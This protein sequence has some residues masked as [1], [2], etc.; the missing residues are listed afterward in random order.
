[1]KS[2]LTIVVSLFLLSACGTTS[3]AVNIKV[4]SQ[5]LLNYRK[6][7]LPAKAAPDEAVI[8]FIRPY[9]SKSVLPTESDLK[10]D[11]ERQAKAKGKYYASTSKT[12]VDVYIDSKK[13]FALGTSE[14]Y[15]VKSKTGFLDVV[16]DRTWENHTSQRELI[17]VGSSIGKE[18]MNPDDARSKP[19]KLE[20]QAGKTY[21]VWINEGFST[22][23]MTTM[24]KDQFIRH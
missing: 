22:T 13:A 21:Y 5:D 8:Y 23:G 17:S 20:V 4:P 7:V 11:A 1:M 19:K 3:P 18:S 16:L 15:Y 24:A 12:K 9:S 14:N 6:F 10:R 2:L